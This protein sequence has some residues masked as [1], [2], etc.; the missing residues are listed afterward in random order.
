MFQTLDRGIADRRGFC[1]RVVR[2]CFASTL[3]MKLQLRIGAR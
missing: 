1:Q 2:P 3:L